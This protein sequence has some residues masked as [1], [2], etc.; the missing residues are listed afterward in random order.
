VSFAL[1]RTK[2]DKDDKIFD[3]D[4]KLHHI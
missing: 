3:V 4:V 2:A 1:K